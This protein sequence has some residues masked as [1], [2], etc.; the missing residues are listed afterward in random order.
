MVNDR[1]SFCSA[2]EG[3]ALRTSRLYLRY[4]GVS[5]SARE[6]DSYFMVNKMDE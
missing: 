6:I 2:E 3:G 1:L 4:M 5:D